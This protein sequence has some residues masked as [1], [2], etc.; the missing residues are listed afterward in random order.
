[1]S[2][3]RFLTIFEVAVFSAG[4]ESPSAASIVNDANRRRLL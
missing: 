4:G 2:G 3:S 1:M